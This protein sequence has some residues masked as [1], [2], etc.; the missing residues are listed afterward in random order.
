MERIPEAVDIL[1]AEDEVREHWRKEHLLRKIQDLH[2]GR[3]RFRFL[4]GPPTVNGFM[5]VGHA[6]GRTIKDVYLRW[7]GMQGFDVWRQAGWDCQGLPVELEVEKKL[8]LASKKDI[9]DKVGVE[10]FVALCKELVDSYLEHWRSTSERLGLSLDY[11]SAYETRRDAYIE[12]AW[13]TLKR[14]HEKGMLVEDFK[15]IP[16][17]PRCETPL[18]GHEVAQGYDMATDPSIYVKFP[19]EG[20]RGY[21]VLIW[22]T[23]PWTLLA[24][25]AIAV[26][27]EVTYVYVKVGD[28]RWLIAEPLVER[29][30]SDLKVKEYTVESRLQG[31][32]LVGL[33][34]EHPFAKE[35]TEHKK[36]TGKNHHSI[37]PAEYVT[38]EDG[39]GCV[40]TAPGHGPTIFSWARN[41]I[42]HS[43][44]P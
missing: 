14:A 44:L 16:F 36:H 13:R 31:S 43:S 41:T 8:G 32:K 9:E 20:K 35:V 39:T 38:L 4:E 18:S 40:H 28:E 24:N 29:V 15:V 27:P 3:S 22:T 6:R 17:C 12:V 34:Y 25:E 11:E 7:R 21:H 2:K 26:H 33:R 1:K 10:K 42:F 23:T 5:H 37:L 30:M 19:L